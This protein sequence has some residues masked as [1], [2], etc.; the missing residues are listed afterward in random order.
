M[1]IYIR[2]SG[3]H[4]ASGS[5]FEHGYHTIQYTATDTHGNKDFCTIKFRVIGK[6]LQYKFRKTSSKPSNFDPSY[7]FYI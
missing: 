2:V 1:L 3:G 7:L 5:E 4:P 6:C